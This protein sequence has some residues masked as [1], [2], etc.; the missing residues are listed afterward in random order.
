FGEDPWPSPQSPL[1]FSLKP[2]GLLLEDPVDGPVKGPI[3]G[4]IEGPRQRPYRSISTYK[5]GKN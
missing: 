3:E 5:R 1:A 2:P 4:P